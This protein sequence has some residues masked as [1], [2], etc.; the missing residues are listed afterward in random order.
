MFVVPGATHNPVAGGVAFSGS[1]G[2]AVSLLNALLP[3]PV[4]LRRAAGAGKESWQM[5]SVNGAPNL[6]PNM[7]VSA[8]ETETVGAMVSNTTSKLAAAVIRIGL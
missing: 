2:G 8:A 1:G 5:G 4:L 3:N 7:S 6:M